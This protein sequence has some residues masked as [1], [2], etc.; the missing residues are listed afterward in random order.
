MST[1]I[2]FSNLAQGSASV[3]EASQT[4]ALIAAPG[5]GKS[6]RLIG[7]VV[8]VTLAATGGGGVVSIKDGTTVI[9]SA[10]ASAAGNVPF[11]FGEQGYLVTANTAIN[12]VAESATTNEASANVAATAKVIG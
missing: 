9:F 10:N 11:F 6:L 3:S 7:G 5:A 12:V 1:V 8:C 2:G 4:A